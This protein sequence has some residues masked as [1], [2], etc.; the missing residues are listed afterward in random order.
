MMLLVTGFQKALLCSATMS[1][2]CSRVTLEISVVMR[3]AAKSGS[4]ITVNPA[5]LATVSNTIRASLVIFRLMGARASGI[6]SGGFSINLGSSRGGAGGASAAA[7][8]AA[9]V[10]RVF[11]ISCS[12]IA[13]AGS[14]ARAFWN[15][16]RACWRSPL[17]WSFWPARTCASPASKRMRVAL[18]LYSVL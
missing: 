2:A 9:I 3:R 12:A 10:S 6:S 13:L 18:S 15:S 11:R 4:K 5:S 17:S 1:R 7:L 14:I 16:A 8:R